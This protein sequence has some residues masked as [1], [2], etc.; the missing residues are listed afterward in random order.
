MMKKNKRMLAGILSLALTPIFAVSAMETVPGRELSWDGPETFALLVTEGGSQHPAVFDAPETSEG[1]SEDMKSMEV[2]KDAKFDPTNVTFGEPP[3]GFDEMFQ[4]TWPED[5]PLVKGVPEPPG[6]MQAGVED[7]AFSAMGIAEELQGFSDY[8]DRLK[9]AGF[10]NG[11]KLSE[12]EAMGMYDYYAVH[13]DGRSISLNWMGGLLMLEI[14]EDSAGVYGADSGGYGDY[15]GGY[16]DY[17]GGYGDYGGSSDL[18]EGFN[19]DD[20]SKYLPEGF[21]INDYLP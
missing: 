3:E 6:L 4:N 11:A 19:P 5:E 15:S 20:Y 17:D 16:G 2:P 12:E 21:D 1:Y 10:K 14:S 8:V 18:P 9:A 7:G 13:S